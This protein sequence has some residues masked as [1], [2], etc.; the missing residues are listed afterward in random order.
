METIGSD[1]VAAPKKSSGLGALLL[2]AALLAGAEY[3]GNL[4][5]QKAGQARGEL[6]VCNKFAETTISPM[7]GAPP[8]A[9]TCIRENGNTLIKVNSPRGVFKLDLD[10]NLVK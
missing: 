6:A 5:G 8:G 9:I 4:L 3:G 1:G 10:G 2:V 7:L